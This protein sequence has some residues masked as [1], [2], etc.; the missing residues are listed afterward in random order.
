MKNFVFTTLAVVTVTIGAAGSA[1]AQSG[2]GN[3]YLGF[4]TQRHAS[5]YSRTYRPASHTTYGSGHAHGSCTNGRCGTNGC[6]SG[7]GANAG[8]GLGTSL[9]SRF[10]VRPSSQSYLPNGRWPAPAYR[11][12]APSHWTPYGSTYSGFGTGSGSAPFYGSY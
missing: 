7:Y 12:V 5:P 1:Q 3:S 11:P 6:H 9:G 8:Y 10:G 2:Y 4:N